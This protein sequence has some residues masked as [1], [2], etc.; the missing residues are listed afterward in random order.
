MAFE[1]DVA[2]QVAFREEPCAVGAQ[3][4]TL[5]CLGAEA[6]LEDAAGFAAKP[7]KWW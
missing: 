2:P 1:G 6:A 3:P 7:D 4:P 5:F